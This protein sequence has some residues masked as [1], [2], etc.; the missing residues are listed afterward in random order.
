MP[1]P[2]K[3]KFTIQGFKQSMS[4]GEDYA[5]KT[6]KILQNAI[7]EIFARNTGNLSYEELYRYAYN[8]VLYKHG[9]YL[10]K[11]LQDT[12]TSYLLK[13]ADIVKKTPE[14]LVLREVHAQWDSYRMSMTHVR[15]IF[16]YMDRTY[17]L[18]EKKMHVHELGV[19]L[20]RDLIIRN[21]EISQPIVNA[22]LKEVE[23]ERQSHLVEWQLLSAVSHLYLDMGDDA[24]GRNVY[25]HDLESALLKSTSAFYATESQRW[26]SELSCSEYLQQVEKRLEEEK[27]RALRYLDLRTAPEIQERVETELIAKHMTSL[28]DMKT[29]LVWMLQ[30]D[31]YTEIARLHRLFR[32]IRGGDTILQQ[33]LKKEIIEQGSKKLSSEEIT[34]DPALFIS[35]VLDMKDKY[36]KIINE[37][38]LI[39]SVAAV[40]SALPTAEGNRAAQPAS[41][42]AEAVSTGG[43]APRS[44]AAP[45]SAPQAPEAA[46]APVGPSKPSTG[47]T[48]E[49]T[50]LGMAPD[51]RYVNAENE[52]FEQFINGS[53]SSAEYLSLY[54]DRVLRGDFKELSE[55]DVEAKLNAC[56]V[57]F[58]FLQNKDVFGRYFHQH[59][60][61]RLLYNRST[62]DDT[63]RSFVI[64]LKN[65]CGYLYTAKMETMF[66]DMRTSAYSVCTYKSSMESRGLWQ[67]SSSSPDALEFDLGVSILTTG[68]WPVQTLP[69]CV[70]PLSIMKALHSFE[71]YYYSCH[72]GRQL[73]WQTNMGTAD[74][75]AY[76]HN[77][78]RKHELVVTTHSMSV[79]LL[80][81]TTDSMTF[82]EILAET[83]IPDAELKR[84]LQSLSLAK[85]R[86]L[87]KKPAT[88]EVNP[89]DEFSF[90]DSFTN[91]QMRIRIQTVA[92]QKEDEREKQETSERI[93][94]DRKPQIEAAIV[95]VMKSRRILDHHALIVEVTELLSGRFQPSPVDIKKRIESLIERE[96]LVRDEAD[97]R[98]YRYVA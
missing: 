85:Y 67:G 94:G 29:G 33:C 88:K 84:V 42:T 39:K 16:M 14:S 78:K 7:G 31:F 3:P 44:G 50:A 90:N 77:F 37:S 57:V 65:E 62:S 60:A 43:G 21:P 32:N 66:A 10:Y 22:F 72:E 79:L 48:E 55:D 45:P 80:F 81:N 91:K 46:R 98:K 5:E 76:F 36:D 24:E 1:P 64:K 25:R 61:K 9:P 92:A 8:M 6:W 87:T 40:T 52:A 71:T 26:M 23:R 27:D 97:Q 51:K 83:K 53:S 12:L 75:K 47:A 30:N 86:V 35:S 70:L 58:R 74:L 93:E 73:S 41:E 17:I 4:P 15:D 49:T 20:F 54:V 19:A 18:V 95:R 34:K 38:F 68:A 89:R 11:G 28:V 56:I 13:I 63:E 2:A 96:F 82:E 59:L 69:M